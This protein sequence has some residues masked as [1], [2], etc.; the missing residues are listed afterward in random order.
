[1]NSAKFARARARIFLSH[2]LPALSNNVE[3]KMRVHF[4]S[5]SSYVCFITAQNLQ[6]SSGKRCKRAAHSLPNTGN[7]QYTHS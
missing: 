1:M 3:W 4:R 7:Q 6:N 5:T 2:V